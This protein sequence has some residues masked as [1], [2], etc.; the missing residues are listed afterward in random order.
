M[1]DGC[2]FK[3]PAGELGQVADDLLLG[4]Q[5]SAPGEDACDRPRYR[6]RDGLE[7]VD[8]GRRHPVLVE[9]GDDR[10]AVQDE[11]RVGGGVGEHASDRVRFA[12]RRKLDFK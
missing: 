4:I 1:A 5:L 11:E 12:V 9:L 6:L 8:A 7:Q 2:S 10:A 3:A